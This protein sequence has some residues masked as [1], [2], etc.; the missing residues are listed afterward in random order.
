V[1]NIKEVQHQLHEARA[2]GKHDV[3]MR[4]KTANNTRF[5]AVPVGKA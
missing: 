3:L 1:S 5:I 4:V 2:S